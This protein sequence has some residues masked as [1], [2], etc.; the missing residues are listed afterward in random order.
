MIHPKNR[1]AQEIARDTMRALHGLIRVGMSEAEIRRAAETEMIARGSNGWWY[2]GIGA[3]VLLGKR[4]VESMPGRQYA[5]S[6][7][8]RVAENDVI[9]ID[10]APT[11]D[12]YWGDYARTIFVEDGAVAAPDAPRGVAYRQGLDAELR[13][14][15]LLLETARPEIAYEEVYLR[16]NAEITKLGFENLDVHGNLGHSVEMDERQRIYLEGGSSGSFAEVGRAF[17]FEPHIRIP[18]AG[19]GFKREDIYFF[20]DNGALRRL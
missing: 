9:T 19:V 18:G 11:V 7:D 13:L 14:H 1:V 10:L 6:P 16:M 5:A 12:G 8:N 17:T 20:D 15:H 3:L 2:H 4:S